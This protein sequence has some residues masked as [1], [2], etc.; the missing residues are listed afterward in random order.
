MLGHTI[1]SETDKGKEEPSEQERAGSA[2]SV[3]VSV[4]ACLTELKNEGVWERDLVSLD[5][6]TLNQTLGAAVIAT[7]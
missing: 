3:C 6:S 5:F 1:P 4:Q 2:G 7:R